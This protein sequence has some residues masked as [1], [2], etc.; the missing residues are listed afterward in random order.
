MTKHALAMIAVFTANRD[1]IIPMIGPPPIW[2]IASTWPFT[3]KKVA[4]VEESGMILFSQ[5]SSNGYIT[6]LVTSI[7][8]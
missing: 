2:P 3:E 8:T 1:A 5:M 4:R 7:R 6:C